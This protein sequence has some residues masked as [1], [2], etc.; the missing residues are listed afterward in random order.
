M[1]N[2]IAEKL[3]FRNVEFAF[4]GIKSEIILSK[5]LEYFSEIPIMFRV[6]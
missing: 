4:A 5:C 6:I 1:P 2:D 3:H